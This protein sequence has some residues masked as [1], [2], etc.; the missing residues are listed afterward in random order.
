MTEPHPSPTDLA[1]RYG[2]PAPWRRPAAV[3][4]VVALAAVFL[5]WV[6][7]VA[8]VH[9]TPSAESELVSFEVTSDSSAVAHIDVQLEDGADASCRVRAFAEDHTTVGEISFVPE[10]GR[11]D[12]E[13]R[14]ERRATSIDLIGC[15]T[16][17][18]ERPR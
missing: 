7:W 12:V 4:G 9:G 2:A 14:T 11:N 16:P 10:Q 13:V 8:W 17:D 3:V 15:T 6:G 18:Q 5:V 1:E